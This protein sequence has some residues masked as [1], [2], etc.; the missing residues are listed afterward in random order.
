LSCHPGGDLL[1][2][3]TENGHAPITRGVGQP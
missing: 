2:L 3:E 1:A